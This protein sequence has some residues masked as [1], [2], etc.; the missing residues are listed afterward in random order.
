MF[1][2]TGW[3]LIVFLLGFIYHFEVN[4]ATIYA[5]SCSNSD[6]QNAID[7]ATNGDTV[8]LPASCSATWNS[9]VT[10]PNSKG[11]TIDGKEATIARGSLSDWLPLVRIS[12]NASTS[13]RVTRIN[14]TDSKSSQGYFI[15]VSGGTESSAKFRI[16]H[17]TFTG[18]QMLRH[19]GINAPVYGLIDHNTLTWSGNNEVIH[20]EAYGAASTSGWANDVVPGSANAL[21][22][23]DNTFTN[24][25][26]GNP[27]YFW[28]GSAVQGYYGARTVIRYNTMNMAQIDMHGTAG[29]IGARWWE[30]YENTF[31]VVQNG[32]QSEYMLIR[33]GSGVIF[34]NHKTGYANQGAGVIRLVEED[35][36]YPALYQIGRGKNQAL[37]PA[38]VW[39]NDAAISVR[40]GSSNVQ[41]NRD[42]Y[43]STKPGYSPYTYPHPMVS[44]T[45]APLSPPTNLRVQ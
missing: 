37:A 27:A 28:G 41:V 2:I 15:V 33:A 5:N 45:P 35:S 20:N 29:M 26:S 10:I 16:D 22:I 1:K 13:V 3:T 21:Y 9:G 39:G 6:V 18:L 42:Y 19:I 31:N 38:Y 4:A 24:Q 23:E 43:L 40:S 8:I 14:F 30:I 11:I 7:S 12:P 34:N 17:C 36:E 32:N 44:G 25:V